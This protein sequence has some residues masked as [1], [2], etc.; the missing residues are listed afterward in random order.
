MRKI[1]KLLVGLV[2]FGVIAHH[3]YSA[4]EENS[5]TAAKMP[6]IPKGK[7]SD[8]KYYTADGGTLFGREALEQMPKA[9]LVLWLAGN[10]FFAMDEVVHTFQKQH[11]GTKV[12]LITLP[13]GL[14]LQAI[15][16]GG[17][18]YAEKDYRELPDIYAS[19][20][21]G[22]LKQL[23]AS[24][25]M[26]SY[27]VYML[28]ATQVA[29]AQPDGYTL[30]VLTSSALAINQ[31]LYKQINYSPENDFTPICLYVKSPLILAVTPSMPIKLPG[32]SSAGPTTLSRLSPGVTLRVSPIMLLA[33]TFS[34]R[35]R[36]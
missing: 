12:G 31:H 32:S 7:E 35:G 33:I 21:L 14:L 6:A 5:A 3:G 8:V 34:G 23:K 16:A 13:P 15:K 18:I 25:A 26:D 9:G 1:I 24:G 30:V 22:H 20:N 10:Q 17:W 4:D 27:F 29:N 28:A 19:V 36:K 11:P 2:L